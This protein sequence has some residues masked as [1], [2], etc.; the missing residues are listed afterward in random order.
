MTTLT[1]EQ[2]ER[3]IAELERRTKLPKEMTDEDL[4][5]VIQ[6]GHALSMELDPEYAAKYPPKK[7]AK[8]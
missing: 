5:T 6:S 8:R 3:V 2:R 7:G 1:P 4:M